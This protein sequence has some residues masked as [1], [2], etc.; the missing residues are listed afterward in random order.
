VLTD[1]T[2]RPTRAADFA[3]RGL[4]WSL[5][6][7]GLLRISWVEGHVV[8][9]LITG[10]AVQAARL[11]GAPALPV[12]A[13]LACSG[14]DAIALCLGAILAYPVRW[15]NRVAGAA[16][17]LVLILSL[18][19]LRIG[20]L[21]R[22]TG[23]PALFSALHLYIWPAALTLAIAGY[24]FGWMRVADTRPTAIVE[25][26]AQPW[27][28]FVV[29]TMVFVLLFAAVSPLYLESPA[30]LALASFIA[31][32]AAA[33]LGAAG[34]SAHAAANVLWTPRGGFVVTQECITTPLIPVY[35]AAVCA[36]AATWR[37]LVPGVLATLPLFTALG[38]LRLL[39][40]ALPDAGAS[41]LF[42][43]HA[44][45]QLLLA[46]VVVTA[47]ALWGHGQ[48]VPPWGHGRTVP[49]WGH[50]GKTAL[51]RA[52]AG[53]IVGVL[54]VWL[55]GGAYTR[56]IAYQP[57][58]PLDDP[59]G[60]L[61]L[62]PSFQVGLYLALSVAALAVARWKGFLI[63]LAALAVTQAVGLAA[64]HA[65][66]TYPDLALHVRDVRAWAVAGPVLIFAMV[67]HVVPARR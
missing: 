59:Q 49:P 16:G 54:F 41:P 51:G 30:V 36:Y 13:T 9:P 1:T 66:T 4:A 46:A 52:L 14:A 12:E 56:A 25:T 50:G 15:R 61:A 29:L 3:L 63:G 38:V 2:P 18:N 48:T 37:R 23:S 53:A 43:V 40:V 58:G 42:F 67:V 64:L 7:F 35:L 55:L 21:G 22:A 26:T 24:V 45:Y 60:A 65:F 6:L 5:G 39:V 10:Q 19:T 31:R 28:R 32:A 47:A 62:L 33:T 57:R 11:F 34:V 17:G 8:L 20:T 27:R 44:F